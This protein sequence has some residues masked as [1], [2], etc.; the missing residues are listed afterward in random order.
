M[1]NIIIYGRTDLHG[2]KKEMQQHALSENVD[3]VT[4]WQVS[5]SDEVF[6]VRDLDLHPRPPLQVAV[7][8]A[9]FTRGEGDVGHTALA[10]VPWGRNTET[11]MYKHK[12]TPI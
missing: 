4:C 10:V 7:E 8:T 12:H 3:R 2:V 9:H 5:A 6:T 1:S 11:M